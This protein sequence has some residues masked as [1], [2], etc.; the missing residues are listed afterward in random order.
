MKHCKGINK[1]AKEIEARPAEAPEVQGQAG[2]PY[3]STCTTVFNPGWENDGGMGFTQ[4]CH[5]VQADL[6]GTADMYC[7]WPAQTPDTINNPDWNANCTTILKDWGKLT[8]V[9]PE[10]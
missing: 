1:R 4:L 10:W 7:W 9:K 8:V 6:F 2:V 3:M 5:P